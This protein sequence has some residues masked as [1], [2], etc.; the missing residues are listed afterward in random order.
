M[1]LVR[2]AWAPA[3][4]RFSTWPGVASALITTTGMLRVA[5]SV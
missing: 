4:R 2:Y 3:A 1:G 5:G